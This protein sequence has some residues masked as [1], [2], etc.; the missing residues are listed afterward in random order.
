M[1]TNS[2]FYRY[3]VTKCELLFPNEEPFELKGDKIRGLKIEKDFDNYFFPIFSID[4]FIDQMLYYKIVSMKT[5]VKFRIKV[6]KHKKSVIMDGTCEFNELIIDSTFGI[7]INDDSFFINEDLYK[8]AQANGTS[9]MT[10]ALHTFYLFKDSDLSSSKKTINAVLEDV[11]M[12]DTIAYIL[13]ASGSDNGLLAMTIEGE[14]QY[15]FYNNGS[16][17]FYDFDRT[18]MLSRT[19]KLTAY[20]TGEYSNVTVTCFKRSNRNSATPGSYRDDANYS[21]VL[22]I[23][24]DNI[25]L[26]NNAI[27]DDQTS[28]SNIK[29]IN[30]TSGNVSYINPDVE[31]R[32]KTRSKVIV[33][34][35]GNKFLSSAI[36]NAKYE[37][38]HIINITVFDFD[39]MCLTPNKKYTLTFE[40]K[41]VNEKYSG[42]YRLCSYNMLFIQ[43]GA[44]FNIQANVTMK[45]TIER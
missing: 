3:M 10:G 41:E 37:N 18:Y 13:S 31:T 14:K 9:S 12:T 7:Y 11:T 15:G 6:E 17:L 23:S 20:E 45:K 16:V 30:P 40:D 39:Y 29:L 36:E 26:Y 1:Q 43:Q 22:H 28:G 8:A 32:N 44:E 5:E 4:L 21:Y 19:A 35:L 25:E 42:N 34:N 33:N 27:I 24:Q 38:A 2:S